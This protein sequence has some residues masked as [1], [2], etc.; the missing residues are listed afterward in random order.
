MYNQERPRIY[1]IT[2]A[3]DGNKAP[4]GRAFKGDI[5]IDWKDKN[6]VKGNLPATMV[7]VGRRINYNFEL[8]EG[9]P[10][11]RF[12]VEVSVDG[13]ATRP[14]LWEN[15]GDERLR[16][17]GN[18]SARGNWRGKRVWTDQSRMSKKL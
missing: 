9:A 5:R 18:V 6:D 11:E 4:I 14:T 7:F 2:I 8:I 1:L 3:P 16:V 13:E 12:T 15:L 10:D 17:W